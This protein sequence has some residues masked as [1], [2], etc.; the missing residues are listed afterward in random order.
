MVP[1]F[2]SQSI[3]FSRDFDPNSIA[4]RQEYAEL[5]RSTAAFDGDTIVG[6][7]GI[8]SFDLS[9]PGGTAPAAGVTW[10]SVRASHRRKGILTGG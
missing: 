5:D 10:V 8:Y 3:G 6:T 7:A 4:Q 1:F 2:Q 9:I